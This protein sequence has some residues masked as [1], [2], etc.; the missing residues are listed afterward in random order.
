MKMFIEA[1]QSSM[2]VSTERTWQMKVEHMRKM[3][4]DSPYKPTALLL[5]ALDE[6]ACKWLTCSLGNLSRALLLPQQRGSTTHVK[7]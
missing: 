4:A 1:N 7:Q 5:S 3:M 6:T 2:R